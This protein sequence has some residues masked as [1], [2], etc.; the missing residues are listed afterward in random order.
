VGPFPLGHGVETCLR[1]IGDAEA[2]R[3]LC[4]PDSFP[5]DLLVRALRGSPVDGPRR[6]IGPHGPYVPWLTFPPRRGTCQASI[7]RR[8]RC[9][10]VRDRPPR[11]RATCGTASRW[12]G[13]DSALEAAIVGVVL[14]QHATRAV[15]HRQGQR[16]H[17]GPGGRLVMAET[18]GHRGSSEARASGEDVGTTITA[19]LDDGSLRGE[20][21][22]AHVVQGRPPS[23]IDLPSDDGSTCGY[24]LARWT[25]SGP[26]RC[27]PSSTACRRSASR[28]G[29]ARLRHFWNRA[30][31]STWR[32]PPRDAS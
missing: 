5:P 6:G 26:P 31:G 14:R 28:G 20:R 11:L 21:I 9:L 25:Q 15:A 24:C 32:P 10:P 27:T 2:G 1:A 30:R 13:T 3:T 16:R 4:F 19:V 17:Q 18:L 29:P 8:M 7:R 23:T 22:G 12:I